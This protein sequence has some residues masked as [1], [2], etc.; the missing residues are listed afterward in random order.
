MRVFIIDTAN[1]GFDLHGGLIGI[2]GGACATAEEKLNCIEE[3]SR[4]VVDGWAIA[5]DPST[6]WGRLAS[7][8]AAAGSVPF[9]RLNRV[10]GEV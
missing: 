6:P 3:V 4:Y 1:R 9:V 10:E 7:L 8:A 2:A 5:A